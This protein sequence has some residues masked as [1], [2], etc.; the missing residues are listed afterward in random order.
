[1]ARNLNTEDREGSDAQYSCE[2]EKSGQMG[3]STIKRTRNKL[4]EEARNS[5]LDNGKVKNLVKAFEK[6]CTLPSPKESDTTEEE[7]I[8]E[9]RKKALQW[10]FPGSQPPKALPDT[11]FSS[12]FSLPGFQHVGVSETNFSSSSSF[13][14][15]GFFLTSENLGL[16]TRIS[17]SSSW[18]GSQGRLVMIAGSIL[19]TPT[20]DKLFRFYFRF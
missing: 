7:E 1:M 6:L 8:K 10:A 18:D 15:S 17:I 13:C 3:S 9:N 19:L 4:L 11:E 2:I 20:F 14:P 12:S 16:D 5:A